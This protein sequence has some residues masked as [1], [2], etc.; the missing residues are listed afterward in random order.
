MAFKILICFSFVAAGATL[1]QQFMP[2]DLKA[3]KWS[4]ERNF[5]AIIWAL[6]GID[7]LCHGMFG[8]PLSPFQADPSSQWPIATLVVDGALIAIGMSI[9]IYA[10]REHGVRIFDRGSTTFLATIVIGICGFGVL[11]WAQVHA[12]SVIRSIVQIAPERLPD[13]QKELAG[14]FAV[15]GWITMVGALIMLGALAAIPRA[16]TMIS[17]KP[18]QATY[19]IAGIAPAIIAFPYFFFAWM[20]FSASDLANQGFISMKA[21]TIVEAS[22][23]ENN[24]G[25][26]PACSNLKDDAQIAF[27]TSDEPV[28]T[29]VLVASPTEPPRLFRFHLEKCVSP[30]NLEAAK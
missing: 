19:Y 23:T 6:I 7:F 26:G 30:K 25:A 4:T 27:V 9:D 20:A 3:L 1:A 11:T 21:S 16:L 10:I 5:I 15:L 29:K 18:L 12:D 2:S 8:T 14:F 24:D 22:F 13:A 28:P 17:A